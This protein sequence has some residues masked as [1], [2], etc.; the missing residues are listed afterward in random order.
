MRGVFS[1]LYQWLIFIPVLVVTSIVT[2]ILVMLGC[3]IGR[4]KFW[5]YT[6]PRYWSK[7]ICRVALCRIKVQRNDKLNPG[8][9]YIFVANH[10]GAFDI[11]LIYGYLGQDIKWV[12][13]YELRKIPFVGKASEIAGH[14]FV[15]NS[16]SRAM[17]QTIDKAE[18]EL[19]SGVSMAIF[20]EGQRTY[21]GKLG[22]FKRGAFVIATQ[23]QLPIVP[24]TLNG[25]YDILKI[26][27]RLMNPG[28]S[29]EI[30]IHDPIPTE[31]LTDAD[32]PDLM[33]RTHEIIESKL[34]D[35]YK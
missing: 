29:M 34:W 27:S 15:D 7:I 1:F 33:N 26:H 25:P 28:K 19:E 9:S 4:R 10:Q 24:I 22:R 23:M 21:T 2:A 35:K 31:G 13:K 17:A 16:N 14:V 8:Q 5:G 3:S 18:R 30:I 20:P 6:P 11:F 12:Q 32:I